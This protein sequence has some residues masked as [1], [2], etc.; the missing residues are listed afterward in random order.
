[1]MNI[2]SRNE[3]NGIYFNLGLECL[4][5]GII[6][7]F[8]FHNMGVDSSIDLERDIETSEW[9]RHYKSGCRALR[10]EDQMFPSEHA[11]YNDDW[12]LFAE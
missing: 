4:D 5:E 6:Y 11:E 3:S 9:G 7:N 8:I 2:I 1:M 12:R 10:Q